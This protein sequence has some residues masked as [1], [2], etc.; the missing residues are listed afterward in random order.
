MTNANTD[1]EEKMTVKEQIVELICS[2][3]YDLVTA[4]ELY[5]QAL[6]EFLNG[7]EPTRTFYIGAC[8]YTLEKQG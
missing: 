3:G 1:I 8:S 7:Y 2:Q 4:C 6:Q 5:E